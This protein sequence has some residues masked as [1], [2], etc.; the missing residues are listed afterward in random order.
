MSTSTPASSPLSGDFPQSDWS[1]AVGACVLH[2]GPEWGG[3]L[4]GQAEMWSKGASTIVSVS[5]QPTILHSWTINGW[6]M[7]AVCVLGPGYNA[8]A[9]SFVAPQWAALPKMLAGLARDLTTTAITQSATNGL[10]FNLPRDASMLTTLWD[11]SQDP[12]F[13]TITNTAPTPSALKPVTVSQQLA[14]PLELAAGEHV[15]IG[16]WIEPFLSYS[17]VLTVLT[18]NW[19]IY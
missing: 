12:T 6:S 17:T 2:D 7:S 13:P 9:L 8:G 19:S 15:G 4:G 16:L 1:P 14:Q 3:K 5:A 10:P 18:A 11:G